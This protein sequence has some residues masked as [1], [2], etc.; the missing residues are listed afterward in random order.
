M[1]CLVVD[2]GGY[3]STCLSVNPSALGP[4]WPTTAQA[5]Q[6]ADCIRPSSYSPNDYGAQ[7]EH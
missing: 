4:C 5:G 7:A 2:K 1:A 3:M 6:H